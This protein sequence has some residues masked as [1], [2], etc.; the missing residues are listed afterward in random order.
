[1]S[2]ED[3]IYQM[4]SRTDEWA[5]EDV[6]ELRYQLFGNDE[7]SCE[8]EA[9]WCEGYRSRTEWQDMGS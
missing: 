4:L 7:W 2:V 8:R 6:G 3:K 5:N 9:E 1:M